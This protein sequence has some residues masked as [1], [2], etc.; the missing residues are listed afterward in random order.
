[1][2]DEILLVESIPIVLLLLFAFFAWNKRQ[3]VSVPFALCLMIGALEIVAIVSLP[4]DVSIDKPRY[5]ALFYERY[6]W[7][8][9][10]GYKD[11]GWMYY[12]T[13]CTKIFKK[14]VTLFFL[15]TASVYVFAYLKMAKRFFED[16]AFYFFLMA[17]GCM[18]FFSYATNTIR[19]GFAIAFLLLGISSKKRI[20]TIILMICSILFHRSMSI[21]VAAYFITG[22]FDKRQAYYIIWLACLLMAVANVDMGPLFETF[23]ILDNRVEVYSQSIGKSFTGYKQGFRWDF[24]LYSILPL[25][26]S[27]FLERKFKIEDELFSK[28]INMYL[29]TNAVWLLAIRVTYSDRLAYLSWFMIP[30]IMLYPIIKYADK[31]KNPNWLSVGCMFLFMGINFMLIIMK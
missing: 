21:P 26:I 8:F 11:P 17:M 24:L 1:M 18:G 4:D 16:K 14:N 25:T 6:L 28:M 22:L 30:F 5:V 27:L 29:L 7:G 12:V 15:L 31:Y 3:L 23:G 9:L 19:P 10:E 13:L 20:W 2:I